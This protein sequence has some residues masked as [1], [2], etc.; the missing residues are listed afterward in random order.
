[1]DTVF[2]LQMTKSISQVKWL[3]QGYKLFSD[4]DNNTLKLFPPRTVVYN[5]AASATCGH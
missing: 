3:F 2:I 5:T 1:M 4:G